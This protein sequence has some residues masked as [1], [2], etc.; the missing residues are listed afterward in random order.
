M[1]LFLLTALTMV[2]FA[3]NSL[4]NRLALVEGEIGPGG[5]A[6]LR[7]ASGVLVLLA[8][9][10]LRDRRLPGP[11]RPAWAAIAGLSAYM[12]GFSHAYVSMDAGLGALI[13]F[14][15]VQITMFL[16]ALAGGER[17]PPRRWAGMVLSMAGLAVLTVPSGPVPL[18]P[19]ALVLMATAAVGWGIYSLIGRGVTD[20]IAATAWNF[21]YSL[22][23]V[24]AAL[25]IWPD[26]VAPSARG[27]VL[28]V[29]SGGF[30][31]ALGY[32]L[33]YRLLP[34]LGATLGALS[35]LSAPVIALGLGALFLG[36]ALSP[37]SLLAALVILGG[38]ALGLLPLRR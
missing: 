35:Q 21:A 25:A 16:G 22:P 20:P 18:P 10:A 13:L 9:L 26:A 28:A 4:L 2:A 30:T 29:L 23:L 31:S 7:V 37:V 36:E 8:L 33:W 38:I 17:P 3:A 34:R 27:V 14:G 19:A 24:L 6:A 15:G 12:L 32:A 5:F 11:M 1:K